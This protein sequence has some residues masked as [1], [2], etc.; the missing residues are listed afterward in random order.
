VVVVGELA[1]AG[2]VRVS[3]LDINPQAAT[4][5]TETRASFVRGVAFTSLIYWLSV[6]TLRRP[7]R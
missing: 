3:T 2:L 1:V 5:T 4:R 7:A 6:F